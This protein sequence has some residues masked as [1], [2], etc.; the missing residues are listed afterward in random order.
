MPHPPVPVWRQ[1]VHRRLR[2][3]R[4]RMKPEVRERRKKADRA[5]YWANPEPK[6]AQVRK[7]LR[8][9]PL[10]DTR[11]SK[12]FRLVKVG[13]EWD[14]Q[15]DPNRR[16]NFKTVFRDIEIRAFLAHGKDNP[17]LRMFIRRELMLRY[18]AKYPTQRSLPRC[19][20]IRDGPRW[21]Q[22]ERAVRIRRAELEGFTYPLKCP[23]EYCQH[24]GAMA[25]WS[26]TH[27]PPAPG[28]TAA[29]CPSCNG[30]LFVPDDWVA[31]PTVSSVCPFCLSKEPLHGV[32]PPDEPCCHACGFQ[33]GEWDRDGRL[34]PLS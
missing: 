28:M 9:G 4:H 6:R 20:D 16:G 1:L 30:G 12:E 29:L 2:Q 18:P 24:F 26:G 13:A 23:S 17:R 5:R 10:P 15:C 34:I 19:R 3:A 22:R 32:L 8:D 14:L 33:L 21:D 25:A 31:G 7:W 11:L 27:P